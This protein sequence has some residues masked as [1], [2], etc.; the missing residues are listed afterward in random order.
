MNKSDEPLVDPVPPRLYKYRC[1]TDE[2]HRRMLTHNAIFFTSARNFNDPFDCTI[3]VEIEDVSDSYVK[4]RIVRLQRESTPNI[5]DDELQV[6]VDYEMSQRTWENPVELQKWHENYQESK[7]S[8]G[9]FGLSEPRD[10]LL[11]WSHYA[12][13][14]KGFCVGFD[15]SALEAFFK[16]IFEEDEK[17]IVFPVKVEYQRNYPI[18]RFHGMDYREFYVRP[19]TTKSADW[20]YE[21][22]YRYIRMEKADVQYSLDSGIIVEVILGCQM[23]SEHKSEIKEVLREKGSKAELFEARMKEKSFGLDFIPVDN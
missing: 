21:K 5:S 9:I 22:E 2:Y 17:H 12:N 16:R 13:S 6:I 11:M 20:G 8:Q 18:F 7:F 10:N 4:E 1:W 19:L 23:P 3:P 14:H 15:T